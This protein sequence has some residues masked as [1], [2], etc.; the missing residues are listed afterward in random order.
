MGLF[1]SSK[2]SSVLG[3]QGGSGNGVDFLYNAEQSNEINGSGNVGIGTTAPNSLSKLDAK[4]EIMDSGYSKLKLH[5][6]I[7]EEIIVVY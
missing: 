2:S 7:G 6:N 4:M 3:L 5:F 1:C